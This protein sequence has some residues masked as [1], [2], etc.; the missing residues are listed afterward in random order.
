VDYVVISYGMLTGVGG[1]H[2]SLLYCIYAST[3]TCMRETG[4][5]KTRLR[6]GVKQ[7]ITAADIR[8]A[9]EATVSKKV[10][11]CKGVVRRLGHGEIRL[12]GAVV[13]GV[14]ERNG[15][16]WLALGDWIWIILPIYS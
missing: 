10:D 12:S 5:G 13:N 1:I 4:N 16:E 2:T 3:C 6:E 15:S 9:R 7:Q 11:A 14:C 8:Q